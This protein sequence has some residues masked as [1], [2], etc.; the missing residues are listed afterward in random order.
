MFL[1][2]QRGGAFPVAYRARE[3][4]ART[5]CFDSEWRR[6]G[7]EEEG[8]EK[9]NRT[10]IKADLLGLIAKVGNNVDHI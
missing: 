10:Q 1:Q 8:V 6:E 9:K 4:P 5:P 7:V 3:L 2:V